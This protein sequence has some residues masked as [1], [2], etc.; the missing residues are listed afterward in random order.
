MLAPGAEDPGR[1]HDLHIVGAVTQVQLD[2]AVWHARRSRR[3]RSRT[4][5]TPNSDSMDI[6]AASTE[7]VRLTTEPTALRSFSQPLLT[8]FTGLLKPTGATSLGVINVNPHEPVASAV[9]AS[10]R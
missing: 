3:T 5:T 7:M 6:N 9:A 2:Q 1:D 8:A 10:R 4:A